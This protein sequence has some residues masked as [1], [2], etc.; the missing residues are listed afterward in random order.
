MEVLSTIPVRLY[1][2]GD[3]TILHQFRVVY[4][5]DFDAKNK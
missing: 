4:E 3:R 5:C 1:P 2:M